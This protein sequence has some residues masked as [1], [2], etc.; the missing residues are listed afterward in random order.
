MTPPSLTVRVPATSP[1]APSDSMGSAASADSLNA[2][3]YSQR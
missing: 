1:A 2:M 3:T